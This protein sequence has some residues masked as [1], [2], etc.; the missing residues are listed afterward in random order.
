MLETNP[1]PWGRQSSI[2]NGLTAPRL[3]VVRPFP[4]TPFTKPQEQQGRGW[5][6]AA[7]WSRHGGLSSGRAS[8]EKG[9]G[10]QK[11]KNHP[12]LTAPLSS[13]HFAEKEKAKGSAGVTPLTAMASLGFNLQNRQKRKPFLHPSPPPLPKVTSVRCCGK[14]YTSWP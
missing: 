1:A 6:I 9:N 13:F 8:E 4:R 11:K 2:C 5:G 7:R 14:D 3:S 10:V 12:P